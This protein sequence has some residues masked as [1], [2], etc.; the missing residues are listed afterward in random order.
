MFAPASLLSLAAQ[1]MGP[2]A[3]AMFKKFQAA[4]ESLR[5]NL[6]YSGE[7]VDKMI[8]PSK[9]PKDRVAFL[10]HGLITTAL[11]RSGLLQQGI[12]RAQGLKDG[13]EGKILRF[14][15]EE[16]AKQV[17]PDLVSKAVAI[18]KA[19][20]HNVDEMCKEASAAGFAAARPMAEAIARHR[21]KQV[22]YFKELEDLGS[23]AREQ[24]AVVRGQGI[25]VSVLEKV[26]N[27]F[28]RPLD[29]LSGAPAAAA[30]SGLSSPQP[31]RSRNDGSGEPAPSTPDTVLRG[32]QVG[33]A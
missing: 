9:G 15:E 25:D 24:L 22:D 11:M 7:E 21:D 30:G 14:V 6:A 20:F 27:R 32:N 1:E 12:S 23:D 17:D 3:P 28:L 19:I 4:C 10:H 16:W 5:G 2:Q 33:W 26:V 8:A 13:L 31:K 29:D 18:N